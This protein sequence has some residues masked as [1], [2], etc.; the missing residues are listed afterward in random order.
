VTT[1][2]KSSCLGALIIFITTAAACSS[3]S[4][5]SSSP[6]GGGHDTVKGIAVPR[7][8]AVVTATNAT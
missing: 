1:L 7:N 3:S 2:E 4:S 8:V 5:P 6:P